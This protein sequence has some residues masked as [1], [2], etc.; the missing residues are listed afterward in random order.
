MKI[1]SILTTLTALI[2]TATAKPDQMRINEYDADYGKG[3]Q[4][5]Q[6]DL[7][8]NLPR[9]FSC[10]DS[11]SVGYAQSLRFTLK[12]QAICIHRL[13]IPRL[14]PDIKNLPPYS[15]LAYSLID[16]SKIILDSKNIK[17]DYLLL[18]CGLHDI[19]RGKAKDKPAQYQKD[20]QQIIDLAKKHNTQL[21]W[22]QTTPK[23]PSH[24]QN[25]T[26]AKFNTLSKKICTAA[27]IPVIDLHNFTLHM[28]KQHGQTKIYNKDGVHFTP[29]MQQAQGKFI[30]KKIKLN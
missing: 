18:N 4:L 22:V 14:F 17:P 9:I 25:P 1:T 12:D 7:N 21:I 19:H 23:K 11:I 5:T 26:I 10:G 27:N 24:P 2:V 15:G 28:L 8:K 3:H 29:F 30:A 6:A 13:D 16:W 20:L